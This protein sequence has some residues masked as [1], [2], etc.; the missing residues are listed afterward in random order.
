[1]ETK[2]NKINDK[3]LAEFYNNNPEFDIMKF[4]FHDQKEVAHLKAEIKLTGKSHEEAT[5]IVENLKTHQ[6]LLKV[7]P[8]PGLVESLIER[9]L[10]SANHIAKIPPQV[11]VK[12]HAG[13]L[14][15]TKKQARDLHQKANTIRTNTM[16][17]WAS[18][19]G[20]VASPVYQNSSF[21]TLS[22]EV[23]QTFQDLPS[24][25]ELFGSIN[26][27]ECE[28]CNSI[29]G[30][31]AYLVDLLRII[32]EYITKPNTTIPQE[33][34]FSNRRP[35]IGNIPLTCANTNTLVSNIQ[36]VNEVLLNYLVKNIPGVPVAPPATVSEQQDYV[37]QQMANGIFYP[38]ALPFNVPLNQIEALLANSGTSFSSV[39]SAWQVATE[40]VAAT[41]LGLSTEQ[42]SII[43]TAEATEAS[44]D[45]FFNVASSSSLSD[46][47]VLINQMQINFEDLLQLLNQDLSPTEQ[48]AGIQVNFFINQGL[49]TGDYLS[50]QNGA[51]TPFTPPPLK[52]LDQINRITRLS[53]V[54][55]VSVPDLDWALR[56]ALGGYTSP[57]ISND[58]LVT[59]AQF[60]SLCSSL[61]I[62]LQKATTLLGPIKTYGASSAFDSLFNPPSLVAQ[63]GAYQPV[64]N[65]LNPSY[66]T[67]ALKWTPDLITDDNQK[68]LDNIS[69]LSRILS[70]LGIGQQDANALG[71]ALFGQIEVSL[72]VD[73]I[74]SLYRHVL[75]CNGLQMPMQSYL[76]II[77]LIDPATPA[78]PTISEINDIVSLGKAVSQYNVSVYQLDYII[79]N[80]L[81][82]Y[83]NPLYN[84]S[85]ISDWQKNLI[86]TV[87]S[88]DPSTSGTA[89]C[90]QIATLFGTNNDVI[91]ALIN[92]LMS[93]PGG[94]SYPWQAAFLNTAK[95]PFVESTLNYISRWLVL[96][97]TLK[98]S[99]KLI[100]NMQAQ[101]E[102]Y[103][104][105]PT[106]MQAAPNLR[107]IQSIQVVNQ[108]MVTYGDPQQNLLAAINLLP[109]PPWNNPVTNETEILSLLQDATGWS[110]AAVQ[111]LMSLFTISSLD[112]ATGL[113]TN[114]Q[115]CFSIMSSLGTDPVFMNS[116]LELGG[117][118]ATAGTNWESYKSVASNLL[119][120]SV[121]QYGSEWEQV[122]NSLMGDL[123]VGQRDTMLSLAL[124]YLNT[125]DPS[126]NDATT[127]YEYLLTNVEIGTAAETSYIVEATGAAQLYLQRCRLRLEPGVNDLSNIGSEWWEWMLN[128][129]VWQANREIFVYPEN[130]MIPGLQQNASPD[131]Q[132]FAQT[133]Q[134]TN[135]SPSNSNNSYLSSVNQGGQNANVENAYVTYMQ[136]FS[137][138]SDIQVVDSHYTKVGNEVV[139]YL[140][141]RTK[142]SPYTFYYCYRPEGSPWSSWQ[143]IDLTI[144]AATGNLVYAFNRLFVF[145]VEVHQN[146]SSTVTGTSGSDIQTNYVTS[147]SASV[148]YSFIDINTKWV[149]PQTLVNK[150]TV[151]YNSDSYAD[152]DDDTLLEDPLF[153]GLFDFRNNLWNRLCAIRITKSNYSDAEGTSPEKLVIMWGPN[154]NAIGRSSFS[155]TTSNPFTIPEP[156]DPVAADFWQNLNDQE[157]NNYRLVYGQLSGEINLQPAT[158]L[159]FNLKGDVLVNYEEL[160]LSDAYQPT[161]A[162]GLRAGI[163]SDG[164]SLLVTSSSQ[165]ITDSQVDAMASSPDLNANG[166]SLLNPS[167][168]Q[169]QAFAVNGIT[170]TQ[171]QAIFEALKTTDP[172]VVDDSG[173]VNVAALNNLNLYQTLSGLSVFNSFGP[174]QYQSVMAVLNSCIN[175]T[176]LFTTLN[177]Y[178]SEVIPVDGQPGWFLTFLDDESFLL[179]LS[180]NDQSVQPFSSLSTGI[181]VG[182]PLISPSFASGLVSE[183]T[184]QSIYSNLENANPSLLKNGVLTEAPGFQLYTDVKAV[185]QAITTIDS[186]LY[187]PIY[188]C[189]VN[190]PI[191]FIDSFI[192]ESIDKDTSKIIFNSLSSNSVLLLD[193]T[194]RITQKR[195]SVLTYS[196]V[197]NWLSDEKDGEGNPLAVDQ[198]ASVYQTLINAPNPI[199]LNYSNTNGSVSIGG[200]TFKVTRLSTGAISKLN[201]ALF[202]GGVPLL[203][204]LPT[205]QIP[206][207]PQKPFSRFSPT[208]NIHLPFALDATQIDFDVDGLYSQYFWEI[209]YSIPSLVAYTLT[210]QQQFQVAQTWLQYVFNP[211]TPA[212]GGVSADLIHDQTEGL[213]SEADAASIISEL[214]DPLNGIPTYTI[215][216]SE[217]IVNPYFNSQTDL[218]FLTPTITGNQATL[219][220]DLLLSCQSQSI[221]ATSSQIQQQVGLTD[222]QTSSI[223]SLLQNTS[224]ASA[225]ILEAKG[226]VNLSFNSS[227]SLDFLQPII[228]ATQNQMITNILLNSQLSCESAN[229]WQFFPFRNNTLESLIEVFNNTQAVKNYQN[230]PFD[231][232]A[233]ARLR[234]GAYEKATFIQYIDNLIAWGDQFFIQDTRESIISAYMIYNYANDLLGPRPSMVGVCDSDSN[235]LTFNEILN[236]YPSGI[237]P[238]LIDLELFPSHSGTN[239][240]MMAY[241]FND[242]PVYFNVPENTNLMSRWD[243]V[244]DRINK[245]NMSEN[246]DGV[247]QQLPLF[248]PPI[249]P[250]DL[251]KAGGNINNVLNSL[252]SKPAVPFFRYSSSYAT[253]ISLCDVVID[254]G[255]TLLTAL[256]RGDAE[257]LA[258]LQNNQEA[259]IQ[260]MVLQVKEASLSEIQSTISSLHA[261]LQSAQDQLA[262][263]TSLLNGGLSDYEITNIEAS[264]LAME[265]NV[266]SSITQ[267]ASSIGY[268]IPQAGSPFAMTYGGEQIGSSLMAAAG[269]FGIGSEISSYVAQMASTMGG[270]DRRYKEWIFQQ[271][272]AQAQINSVSAQIEAANFQLQGAQLDMSTQQMSLAQNKVMT[273]Y[274]QSKF[275][276]QALYQWMVGQ[277][278]STYFQ[279]FN[280]AIRAAQEAQSCYQFELDSDQAYINFN[281]WNSLYKGLTAGQGLR[282]ALQNLD[283]SYRKGDQRRLEIDKTVS[284]AMTNPQA[285][286]DLKT[287]GECSFT[288]NE[289]M[290]DYDYPGHYSR[291]I[292]SLTIS[293]PVVLGPYQHLK[294]ILTQNW[295]CVVTGN[296]GQG[297][298]NQP[299]ISDVTALLQKPGIIPQPTAGLRV[300]WGLSD[301][302]IAISSGVN[303]SGLFQLDFQ[304][305]RYL[306]FENTGA[307]SN[308]T[309]SM[310]M[311]TNF[312]DFD[313]IS[314]VIITVKYTAL[315]GPQ[316]FIGDVQSALSTNP[317]PGGIYVDC[318]A[319]SS[320]WQTFLMDFNKKSTPPQTAQNLNLIIP[321]IKVSAFKDLTFTMVIVQLV[322]AEGIKIQNNA[323][324]LSVNV[325]PV[326]TTPA[327]LTFNDQMQASLTKL[328]WN[329]LTISK[330]WNFIF[331][332]KDPKIAPL[333]TDGA[334]DGTKL[335]D[336]QIIIIYNA[337]VFS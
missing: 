123:S 49:A 304:D 82:V 197:Q 7:N 122:S 273:S 333:L 15:L 56:C 192:N 76:V 29:F 4:K 43:T 288:F 293:V 298:T 166:V 165:V 77:K 127:T 156:I 209:F 121:G 187:D 336:M 260:Q 112:Q 134:Q 208:S 97:Q 254:L 141:G 227:T 175:A 5:E 93:K 99:N 102:V 129:R 297:A 161:Y 203:L 62:S 68:N 319:Q 257:G 229:S 113:L 86:T 95:L 160:I 263:Y 216:N 223:I 117:L 207:I 243:T 280:L 225:P 13:A 272:L 46:P 246:I 128:Y 145:W 159:N 195:P 291:K 111:E 250:L 153:K 302:S 310:P 90:T 212:F 47:N 60:N 6:R 188:S 282:L 181:T 296:N 231:P 54:S 24:Y 2:A 118:D 267:T 31:A 22:P 323:S 9:G 157:E 312:F 268:A 204:S 69:A 168:Q 241:A 116:I 110:P 70:G 23:S 194:G 10:V 146:N 233:I 313:Q 52:S 120:K 53:A 332:L 182:T 301:Q 234:I 307:V 220:K 237:P 210:T 230:H 108:M 321:N 26:Y 318:N 63:Y 39:L 14:G 45:K 65:Q 259:Q 252:T 331:N 163:T 100:D 88:S 281:Y 107:S 235:P 201:E 75:L 217:S 38:G 253:A 213:I 144:N 300:N 124:S 103:Q 42:Q 256:E 189:L 89:I 172:Q 305:Q 196:N 137:Q 176:G 330:N 35:D 104:L 16:H 28:E 178:Y 284:L 232:F 303:D 94:K 228:P 154:L 286:L 262:Y 276:N 130:Y 40:I 84:A 314:D 264:T 143:K 224:V 218:S 79:D 239:P 85:Q 258:L 151:Y 119:S 33:F 125:M 255:S 74:S 135:I 269:V 324:F 236:A 238:F 21:S 133:L 266:L 247:F 139:L 317:L 316:K 136:D 261:S 81:T 11:F 184:S 199:T 179:S 30:P 251:V 289:A 327:T 186:S 334:I 277:L 322:V 244:K 48:E 12:E 57:V 109:P 162:P 72:T 17:L 71:L 20:A 219:L 242:L 287:T 37:L 3:S 183:S 92:L 149:Q 152:D 180:D 106:T 140:L 308:W 202:A 142:T 91:T 83:V 34:L 328:T 58:T 41:D 292:T 190:G 271:K 61:S 158:V 270:Y 55:G 115:T 87:P 59:L 221:A 101:P 170:T 98:L 198:I 64:G 193:S 67:P 299:N 73:V 200:L 265:F 25:S 19:R 167:S 27:C 36:I 78:S 171:S 215:L 295:N 185:L 245:I 177:G 1:M 174:D 329:G 8:D 337:S 275:T 279:T 191:V 290:F 147:A 205:Q 294:A 32:D 248:Q 148:M 306:P 126:I 211:T 96:V 240:S 66:Q 226:M 18:V 155:P 169:C 309:L 274:L 206:V 283:A 114:L 325:D 326:T 315:C 320:S 50:I 222:A 335:L 150:N 285:L 51:I 131:F 80:N 132:K 311:Q 105:D 138:V 249:N 44:I 173:N 214:Q 278:S 164:T